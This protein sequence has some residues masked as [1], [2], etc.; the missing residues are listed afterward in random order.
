MRQSLESNT[1]GAP[2]LEGALL[3]LPC[4]PGQMTMSEAGS[5]APIL[6]VHSV[7]AA[8][9]SYEVKPIYDHAKRSLHVFALDLP[10]FGLSSR[11]RADYSL[12]FYVQAVSRAAAEVRS[13]TGSAAIDAL[14]LSLS[15]EFLGRAAVE[16]PE[17]F[18][19][20]VFVTPTGF[21]TGSRHRRAAPETALGSPMLESVLNV[22]LWRRA[23]YAGL[24][25]RPSI[26]FFLRRTFGG[27]PP[28]DLIDH[29]WLSAHSPLAEFAP[30]AFASGKLFAADIRDVYER[31]DLP[32]WL[33]HGTKGAFSDFSE[34]DWVRTRPNWAVTP[35][36]T[37]AFPQFQAPD[38]FMPLL[39]RFLREAA[40]GTSDWSAALA[41]DPDA[42]PGRCL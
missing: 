8:A 41:L 38:Q 37:G 24:V 4:P 33:A 5:G 17:L 30:F 22:P 11:G 19:S 3:T 35:F 42:D 13:R 10:G 7:N 23:L 16:R 36:D 6:L 39:D 20:L 28:R 1:S 26:R 27:S 29:A 40:D 12:G 21:E 14:A 9:S 25:S 34:A 32:V 31:L 18:R 15:C 2:V